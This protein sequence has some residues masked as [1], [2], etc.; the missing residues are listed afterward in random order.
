MFFEY[1]IALGYMW[2]LNFSGV[3]KETFGNVKNSKLI[4][5]WKNQRLIEFRKKLKKG[6]R[7]ESPCN[8]CTANGVVLGRCHAKLW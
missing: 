7:S 1:F 2:I 8:K 5:L 6:D 4:D 3:G